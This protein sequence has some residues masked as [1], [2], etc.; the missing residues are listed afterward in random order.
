MERADVLR[1][2]GERASD[3]WG[4]VTAAQAKLDGVQGVDLLRLERAGLL[5]GVGR[6]VYLIAAAVPPE[7]LQTKVAWLRL[8]PKTPAWQRPA[9]SERS[10][11][12]SHAS[13]CELH[14]LGDLPADRVELIVPVRRTTRDEGVLLHRLAL[15][16]G[17]VTVV[18]GLPVTTVERT[19]VDLLRSRADGAHVGTVIADADLKGLLDVGLL[20]ARVGSFARAY[21]LPAVASGEDLLE[22]LCDQ[23]G[24]TLRSR[25][26]E[27]AAAAGFA[28]AVTAV[29]TLASHPDTLDQLMKTLH[30]QQSSLHGLGQVARSLD[31]KQD[32]LSSL[33]SR[34]SA[35]EQLMKNAAA[36]DAGLRAALA[37]P[38]ALQQM[39]KSA[40]ARQ[41]ALGSLAAR[42]NPMQ[43]ALARY[44]STLKAL[45]RLPAAPPPDRPQQTGAEEN[46]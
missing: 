7:H 13:A 36:R 18:D 38:S 5:E 24:R 34:P 17:D 35:L 11:V 27:Q 19:V 9:D 25:E 30:R 1:R 4:L 43:Q 22:A 8:D 42:S 41:S 10:G 45:G 15:E 6:G 3:Q 29:E 12:V 16:E 33:G 37:R 31:E 39:M 2:L 20:A 46:C 32:A 21:G 44:D 40:A 23:A 28:S 26:S 14:G